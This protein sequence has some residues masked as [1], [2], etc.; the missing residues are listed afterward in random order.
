MG[1]YRPRKRLEAKEYVKGVLEGD[2]V[3]LSRA[4]TIVESNLASDK[5][6][7][8]DIIQSILPSS[9]KSIP[10]AEDPST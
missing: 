6:L 1:N 10:L 3:L 2:R 5:I 9:G 7:A 8:K 4:I